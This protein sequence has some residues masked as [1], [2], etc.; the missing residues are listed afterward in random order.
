MISLDDVLR[1]RAVIGDRLYRTPMLPQPA[2][3][4]LTGVTLALKAELFQR[5]GSFKARGV[6]NKL[7][8][9][10]PEERSRGVIGM[11]AGNHAAALA[12]GAALEGIAATVVMPISAPASKVAATRAYGAEVILHGAT[13]VEMV[14]EYER[15]VALRGQ[16]PVHP[17]ADPLVMAGQGTL[18]L[19]I[20]EDMPDLETVIVGIGGGGLIGGVATAIK[21]LA[22]RVR[23]V[24]V[25]PEG[26]PGMTRAL[27]AG[28]VVRLSSVETIADGLAAPFV[29]DLSLAVAHHYVD[30]VVLVSDPDIR[31]AMVLLL[32]QAKLVAEPAGAAALAALLKGRAGVR[33][34][35]QVAV[36]V[37]GGNL[38]R[39]RLKAL[40]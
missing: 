24:G 9:L 5:T 10:G 40:L 33:T 2:L 21:E 32:E 17:F 31:E 35:A 37:S 26:A 38:D 36:V 15:L 25:E 8:S 16:T 28:K 34:G 30:D 27:A 1:A 39:A 4:D 12:F 23:V 20:L 6:L 18:A 11:S 29:S 19:E 13:S 7:A 22:P 3:G 14:E